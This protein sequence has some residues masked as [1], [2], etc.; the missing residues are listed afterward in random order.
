MFFDQLESFGQRNAV[1]TSDGAALSYQT[2]A[3]RADESVNIIQQKCC[4]V[5]IECDNSPGALCAYLGALRAHLPVL[6]LDKQLA[7]ADQQALIS[8]YRIAYVWR[9]DE[10]TWQ[11]TPYSTT[12]IELHSSLAVLL[13]TSGTTGSPKLVRLSHQNIQA[14][15]DSIVEYLGLSEYEHPITALPMHYS[16]GLSIIHSHLAV[17]A[18]LLLTNE[19]ITS[20]NFWDLFKQQ[21]ATSLSAVPTMFEILKQMRFERMDLPSLKTIT[22]AGGKLAPA[23]VKHFA[24]YAEQ[25]DIRLFVMYGQTEATARMAYLDPK[26]ALTKPT[27]IGNA[28]PGGRFE[29]VDTQGTSITQANTE[30]EL[31]YYGPNVMLGYAEQLEHL[32]LGDEQQG[33]LHTGDIAYRDDESFYYITGRLK[34]FL[35]VYGNRIGLDEVE[36]YLSSLGVTAAV[37]GK[38]DLLIVALIQPN[39]PPEQIGKDLALHYRLHHQAVKAFEVEAFP[40][41]SAGKIQYPALLDLYLKQTQ[42]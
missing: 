20:R 31:V 27:S 29:L 3:Q 23:T 6:L 41:S 14:N 25:K 12:T 8:H 9:A 22:Q 2:L 38:D 1:I 32:A 37:T 18:T 36:H 30:G 5:A 24:E 39:G 35:K 17:G 19:S 11:A 42:A 4:L 34:R 15:A 16:F 21:Q 33:C 26:H 28:I 40:I 7:S 13:S 10:Q